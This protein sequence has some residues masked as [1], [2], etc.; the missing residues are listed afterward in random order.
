M[1]MQPLRPGDPPSHLL[2]LLEQFRPAGQ[3][4]SAAA[5]ATAHAVYRHF[6]RRL[7]TALLASIDEAESPTRVQILANPTTAATIERLFHAGPATSQFADVA[8]S[9]QPFSRIPIS[10][11]F[12]TACANY[13]ALS[14]P[15]HFKNGDDARARR[16]RP[17]ALCTS[18]PL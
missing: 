16:P 6:S 11:A 1:T 15:S 8:R 14:R 9:R 18:V 10:A 3:H 17:R 2:D 4:A 7:L 5:S 13:G 12:T